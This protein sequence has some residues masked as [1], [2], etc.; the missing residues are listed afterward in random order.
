[1]RENE[2]VEG[3]GKATTRLVSGCD[4][5]NPTHYF[6][7]QSILIMDNQNDLRIIKNK[8]I[9]NP[10]AKDSLAVDPSLAR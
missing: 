3:E 5:H 6:Q 7:P 4:V 10:E 1:L 9:G 2:E 8:I